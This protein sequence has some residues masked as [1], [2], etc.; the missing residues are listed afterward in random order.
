M[1][2]AVPV[3]N[4]EIFQHFGKAKTF[5]FYEVE[6]GQVLTSFEIG[7]GTEG[8]EGITEFLKA[9]RSDVV[10]CGRC[11]AE[12]QKGIIGSGMMLYAGKEGAADD[13]AR[14][15][16]DGTLEYVLNTADPCK[17]CGGCSGHDP[18]G[19]AAV[20]GTETSASEM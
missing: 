17:G 19:A 2:V 9:A 7:S 5:R 11:G 20:K 13:A 15:F 8:H 6:Q 16:A 12:A 10:I 18:G 14:A 1:R 3:E 4:G